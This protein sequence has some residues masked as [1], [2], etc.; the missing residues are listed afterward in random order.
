MFSICGY[1]IVTLWHCF[2]MS[3]MSCSLK[4]PLPKI[5][6]PLC[7]V[8]AFIIFLLFTSVYVKR[9]SP[10]IV[11]YN[12]LCNISAISITSISRIRYVLPDAATRQC[13]ESIADNVTVTRQQNSTVCE[14][15]K[16]M[17]HFEKTMLPVVRL[18]SC[19]VITKEPQ[20][21]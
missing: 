8:A 16:V 3:I 13:R 10:I 4:L 11:L 18:K 9:T 6:F 12:K 14:C 15:H 2:I 1:L 21:L 19:L 20:L 5:T 7:D 17:L